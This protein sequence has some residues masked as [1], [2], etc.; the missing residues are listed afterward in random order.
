MAVEE[1]AYEAEVG[2]TELRVRQKVVGREPTHHFQNTKE[3]L[4]ELSAGDVHIPE[5]QRTK[6]VAQGRAPGG[7][8]GAKDSG[9][10]ERGEGG[11]EGKGGGWGVGL[12]P[13]SPMVPT[14]PENHGFAIVT[15][16][17]CPGTDTHEHNKH[18]GSLR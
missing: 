6:D 15:L 18:P 16:K 2:T 1:L 8:G 13:S 3:G 12:T 5:G 4:A 17:R 14:A 11:L 10:A 7:G 9:H